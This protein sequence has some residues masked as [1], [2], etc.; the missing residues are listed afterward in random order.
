MLRV[1]SIVHK[2]KN[3]NTNFSI[4]LNAPASTAELNHLETLL[5]RELPKELRDFYL[6]ANGLETLDHLFRLLPIDE[7]I[8]YINELPDNQIYFAEFMIYSDSWKIVF[9]DADAQ[10]YSIVND[11]HGGEPV[12][13]TNSIFEFFERYLASDGIFG[14]DGLYEW[15]EEIMLKNI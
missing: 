14:K 1:E 3:N 7:I 11:D 15:R 5:H 10:S 4:T 8:Q 12:S 2:L 6:L 9:D 13:L